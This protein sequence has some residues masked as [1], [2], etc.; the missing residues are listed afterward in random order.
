MLRDDIRLSRLP[1]ASASIPSIRRPLVDLF[2][3]DFIY[4]YLTYRLRARALGS[5]TS[6]S[7][8]ATSGLAIEEPGEKAGGRG[9]G[10]AQLTQRIVIQAPVPLLST[11]F[12]AHPDVTAYRGYGMDRWGVKTEL[13]CLYGEHPL[14]LRAPNYIAC[15]YLGSWHSHATILLQLID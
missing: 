14:D 4:T 7:G 11:E 15:R 2:Y 5:S 9:N 3:R 8:K 12:S 13:I 10:H 6:G 1:S